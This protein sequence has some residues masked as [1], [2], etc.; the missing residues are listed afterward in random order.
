MKRILFRHKVYSVLRRFVTKKAEKHKKQ[1][2][3]IENNGKGNPPLPLNKLSVIIIDHLNFIR[4]VPDI[5]R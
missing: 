4:S 3:G 1:T 2:Y 5:G